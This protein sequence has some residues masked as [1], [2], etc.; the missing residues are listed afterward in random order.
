MDDKKLEQLEIATLLSRG[1]QLSWDIK[2]A[3]EDFGED[4]NGVDQDDAAA[5]ADTFLRLKLLLTTTREDREA[6][7]STEPI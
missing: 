6:M 3:Y 2:N 7:E 5:L 4:S 1:G